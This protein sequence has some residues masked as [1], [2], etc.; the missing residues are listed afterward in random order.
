MKKIDTES[1]QTV[2]MVALSMLTLLGF[3]GFAA[4][5]GLLFRSQRNMQIAADAAA[6]AA[7]LDYKYNVSDSSAQT[8][9]ICAALQNFEKTCPTSPAPT[10]PTYTT[11]GKTIT[12]SCPPADGPNIGTP[13]FCEAQVSESNSTLFMGMFNHKSMSVAARAVAGAGLSQGCIWA[14]ATSGVDIAMSGVSSV[15]VSNCDIYDDSN[16]T[17]ALDLTGVGSISAKE[18]GIVGNN[19]GYQTNLT[20]SINICNPTCEPGNPTTGI[21]PAASPINPTAPTPSTFSGTC[22]GTGPGGVGCAYN[23]SG[24]SNC[25]IG[26]G[27][28]TSITNSGTGTL[29][30]TAG[31]YDVTG[32]ITNSG[33]GGTILGAGNYIIDGCLCDTG[34][35]NMTTGAG[36]YTIGGN[37]ESSGTSSLTV[38]SGLYIVEGN[39]SLTGTGGLTGT[40]VTFYIQGGGTSPCSGG[41]SCV[42]GVNSIDLTA[43]TSGTY[44]GLLFYQSATD[45]EPLNISGVDSMTLEGI[46][47]APL[48]PVTFGGVDSATIYT[49]FIVDSISFP[50]VASFQSYQTINSSALAGKLTMVE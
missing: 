35:G 21:A 39:L 23:C 10:G 20:S 22:T 17:D 14:L 33:T 5:M 49:D 25:T 29:T 37:F 42:T 46:I 15:N 3:V 40:S 18:I 28:Y 48:A 13:G 12:V 11:G 32:S 34:V 26:P 41:G 36:D 4:D 27:T 2:I 19:P 16:A 24:V 1:G 47:Y 6:V 45:G 9:G 30:L 43:P 8:A 44:N 7:A 38:G 31:N 50:G